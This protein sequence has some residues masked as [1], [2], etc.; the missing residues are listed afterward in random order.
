MNLEDII[1][2]K[3]ELYEIN[4]THLLKYFLI[5]FSNNEIFDVIPK[6]SKD[7]LS[8]QEKDNISFDIEG[9]DSSNIKETSIISIT[10]TK[11]NIDETKKSYLQ[12]I[13]NKSLHNNLISSMHLKLNQDLYTNNRLYIAA[14][15]KEVSVFIDNKI[16]KSSYIKTKFLSFRFYNSYDSI[17]GIKLP[18]PSS[19]FV[20]NLENSQFSQHISNKIKEK[21]PVII[22]D[23]ELLRLNSDNFVD[24][25]YNIL[26]E[27]YNRE[28][29]ADINSFFNF[30]D[31]HNNNLQK[32]TN[33]EFKI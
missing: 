23:I 29:F 11:K 13:I 33:K 31:K 15:D 3:N 28:H 24:P 25:I 20:G 22:E 5:N 27:V 7:F 2:D 6:L 17:N 12:L 10:I 14:L 16:L 1:K 19:G 8:L 4:L 21:I 9:L 30:L 18:E 26:T 32:T